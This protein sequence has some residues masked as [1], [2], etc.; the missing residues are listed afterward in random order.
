MLAKPSTIL[1]AALLLAVA[2]SATAQTMPKDQSAA[3]NVRQS[4]QYDQL[5][6]SNPGFRAR[7]MQEECGPITDPELHAQCIASFGGSPP[8]PRPGPKKH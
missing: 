8:P 6:R 7:R 5:L 1:A 3:E 2:G 4:Q